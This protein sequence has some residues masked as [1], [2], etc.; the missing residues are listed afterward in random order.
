MLENHGVVAGAGSLL[1]AF[2][3][4]EA[5]LCA[6]LQIDAQRIGKPA[7]LSREQAQLGQRQE[8]LEMD[9]L[10]PRAPSGDERRSRRE[11]C[12]LVHRACDQELST[13]TQGTFSR[14][15]DAESFLITPSR[16][17]RKHLEEGDLVRVENGRREAG[18]TPSRSVPL[19]RH[20][21]LQHPHVDAIIVARPRPA[22]WPSP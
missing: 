10:G 14:R 12:D 21:Y 11:L 13:S 6:R 17:D 1:R 20:V 19:H 3:A 18:K 9:E 2:R 8:R 16:L 22:S 7:G 4:F 15:L 5:L